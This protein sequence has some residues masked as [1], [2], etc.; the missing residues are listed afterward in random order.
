MNEYI[1]YKLVIK[2]NPSTYKCKI[3]ACKID[4]KTDK[5]ISTKTIEKNL[6]LNV[7]ENRIYILEKTKFRNT[8]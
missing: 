5:L 4:K 6:D 2:Q 1:Y 7:A 3:V 8:K